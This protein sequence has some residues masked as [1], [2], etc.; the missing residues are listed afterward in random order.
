MWCVVTPR[1]EPVYGQDYLRLS[2]T[3]AF[4]MV[5]LRP[6]LSGSY[7]LPS[8]ATLVACHDVGGVAE[9]Q[10]FESLPNT[11]TAIAHIHHQWAYMEDVEQVNTANAL[12]RA[13]C[14][15]VSASFLRNDLIRRC[16]ALNI[17]IVQNAADCSLFS[18]ARSNERAAFRDRFGLSSNDRLGLF[19]GRPTLAKGIQVIEAFVRLL[20][21]RPRLHLCL[22]FPVPSS[23]VALSEY[24]QVLNRIRELCPDRVHLIE[25]F[26]RQSERPV[27]FVDFLVHPSLSELSPGVVIEAVVCGVPVVATS[28]TPYFDDLVSAGILLGLLR[29]V[30]LPERLSQGGAPQS[31]L[32]L[33]SAEA[34]DLA[35]MLISIVDV[36]QPTDDVR[37]SEF[38]A[39]ARRSG[40]D[41]ETMLHDLYEIYTQRDG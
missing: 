37:R 39:W 8:Q 22:Q 10:F 5:S 32:R 11:I 26:V 21:T 36:L 17:K 28:S 15:I 23:P 20:R 29:V 14:A 24:R 38:S 13:D 33:S 1:A 35:H 3:R 19:V 6:S 31:A 18:P 27:R 16:P 9:S 34:D 41:E 2:A 12:R 4:K 40:H 7:A 25:D 30:S